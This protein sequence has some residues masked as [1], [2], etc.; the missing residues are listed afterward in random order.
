MQV[1]IFTSMP[2]IK[3]LVLLNLHKEYIYKLYITIY[4]H[5][6]KKKF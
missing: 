4:L 6:L 1:V 2:F 3:K 5:S